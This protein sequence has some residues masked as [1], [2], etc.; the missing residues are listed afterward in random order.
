MSFIAEINNLIKY[1]SVSLFWVLS[2][3]VTNVNLTV[4]IWLIR[5]QSL[6]K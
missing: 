1:Y 3:E 6:M 4:A 2:S 5:L